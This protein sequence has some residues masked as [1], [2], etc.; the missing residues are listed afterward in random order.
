[1]SRQ[2][3]AVLDDSRTL[4]FDDDGW[5]AP[6]DGSRTDL[7]VFAY[8]HDYRAAI[9][10]F[11]AVSGPTP[12]APPVRAGQLVEPVPP[13]HRRR[14]TGP[15]RPVRR[16]GHP[17]LASPCIDMDWHL[18][19]V[20]PSIGSGW[21]GYTLEPR[22]CS[23][24]RPAFLAGLHDRGLRVTLNVHPAD[25][26]RAHEDAYPAM[27]ARAG[28]DPAAERA[29]RVRRHRP[30]SSST[31][32]STCCTVGLEARRRRLLVARLAVRPALARG[33]HRP[34][35]DAQPL[36]LPR[37]RARRAAAARRSPATPAP[38]AT[39]TRSGSP[40]T[41]SS[42]WASL[43]FQ[44]YFTAT[45]SNIGYGW[46]SHDI[47]GHMFGGKDDELA[48]R[49]VQ[50]GVFSP[51]LRLHSGANPFTTKEPW[52][53][54]AGRARGDDRAPAPAAPAGALPAHDE[55]PRPR[56][57]AARWSSR[58]T[59]RGRRRPRRT[60]S[61]TSSSSAR[62]LVVAPLT[63]PADPRTRLGVGARLAAR[64]H[65]GRR[66]HGAG[67]RRRPRA[68]AAPRPVDHPGARTAR[69]RSCRST[70]PRC[71]PTTR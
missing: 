8:G 57:R 44:P 9:Q 18:V 55:P 39:A 50:L 68:A 20:D 47:G 23:P 16:R 45:A 63:S 29:D 46:W 42:S 7:Y 25:G 14:A 67:L 37:Q 1:M 11:Y 61:R 32:T 34:A 36:P 21:T 51:I 28:L 22:R 19:D 58:C 5:V 27:A 3:Y 15:D 64:G 17:V 35:V 65:L 31:P 49:W 56:P 52:T 60:T 70:P 48:T 69:A 13:V 10:A 30:A 6:R 38:A 62:E 66:V 4:V 41:P 54:R 43:A 33:R 53:L 71:P 2:G 12:A 24:T 59:T 40:A 26:V